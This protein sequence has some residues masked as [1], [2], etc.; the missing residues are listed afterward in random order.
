MKTYK[1][2]PR[3]NID[4]SDLWTEYHKN[5]LPRVLEAKPVDYVFKREKQYKDADMWGNYPVALQHTTIS[6][7]AP[8]FARIQA[9]ETELYGEKVRVTQPKEDEVQVLTD[10][11][12]KAEQA[13]TLMNTVNTYN[14]NVVT[15]EDYSVKNIYKEARPLGLDKK[16]YEEEGFERFIPYVII[17]RNKP[18]RDRLLIWLASTYKQS[19]GLTDTKIL[20][21]ENG[22]PI[23]FSSPWKNTLKYTQNKM[24]ILDMKNKRLIIPESIK[25][26][27]DIIR[28]TRYG[29]ELIRRKPKTKQERRKE[30]EWYR[31]LKGEDSEEEEEE[32][33]ESE[34]EEEEGE[35]SESDV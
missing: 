16:S 25:D 7:P 21:N 4:D 31:S 33:E 9:L 13:I 5:T 17:R 15:N 35:E 12:E 6:T 2:L 19:T 27:E 23:S 11:E 24:L 30:L 1:G 18:L 10:D 14:S 28:P 8:D 34:E 3:T 22:K 29:A 26:F 32:G 20:Y